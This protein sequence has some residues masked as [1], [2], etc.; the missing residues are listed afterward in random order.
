MIFKKWVKLSPIECLL[1]MIFIG[2]VGGA[3]GYEI[4]SYRMMIQTKQALES[5]A[6]ADPAQGAYIR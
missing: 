2:F 6:K 5:P 1:L 4:G 3:M